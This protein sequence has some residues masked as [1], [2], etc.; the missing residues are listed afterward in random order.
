MNHRI[1]LIGCV[2]II[3]VA[4]ASPAGAVVVPFNINPDVPVQPAGV[5]PGGN[6]VGGQFTYY[7]IQFVIDGGAADI[8][9]RTSRQV[10]GGTPDQVTSD[11]H[12]GSS[13]VTKGGDS[14]L[15]TPF[16]AGEIIGDGLNEFQRPADLFSVLH[17]GGTQNYVQGANYLGIRLASGNYGFV[18]VNYDAA[19][20]TYTFVGGAYENGGFSI[21]AGIPEPASAVLFAAG[22]AGVGAIRRR[23]GESV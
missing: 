4:A 10:D 6:F 19:S 3:A 22:L 17:D 9:I 20:S 12:N 15:N 23:L 5:I 16:A 14:Y 18:T 2:A 11:G 13:I 7:N 21:I 1:W 8:N